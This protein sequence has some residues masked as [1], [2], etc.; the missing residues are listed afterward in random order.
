MIKSNDLL[1]A[2]KRLLRAR[3]PELPEEA[4]YTNLAPSGFIRPSFLVETGPRTMVSAGYGTLEVEAQIIVATFVKVDEL[5]NSHVE[6]LEERTM[7]VQLLFAGGKLEVGA[8]N[9][10][11]HRALEVESVE[12]DVGYDY[13]EVTVTL[14][15]LDDRPAER[16]EWPL[17]EEVLLKSK[18]KE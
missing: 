9:D 10:P 14:R 12:A 2:V 15:Y 3:Y 6:D 1:E 11:D 17:M 13:G 4:L 5:R 7:E 16:E 8:A 18:I